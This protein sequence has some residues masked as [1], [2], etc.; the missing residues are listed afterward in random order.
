[1]SHSSPAAGVSQQLSVGH[2]SPAAGVESNNTTNNSRT[3]SIEEKPGADGN[4]FQVGGLFERGWLSKARDV[5]LDHGI[6]SQND[7]QNVTKTVTKTIIK[8]II[9]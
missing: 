8:T 1:M 7:H 4:R 2:S 9:K 5:I 6:N 3:W